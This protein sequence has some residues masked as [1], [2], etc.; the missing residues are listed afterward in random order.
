[1]VRIEHS[2]ISFVVQGPIVESTKHILEQVRKVFQDAEIILSTWKGSDTVGLDF[3]ILVENDD[4]GTVRGWS[5]DFPG[6]YYNV[7][8]Q[9]VS[10]YN[11]IKRAKSKY[12]VKMRSDL[13]ILNDS[14]LDYYGLLPVK[15]GYSFTKEKILITDVYTGSPTKN[16]KVPHCF[17]PG[18]WFFFGL[19][20]DLE[21]FF[22]LSL[23]GR[24]I[25]QYFLE[26]TEKNPDFKDLLC[27]YHPEQYLMLCNLQKVD[28]SVELE[29]PH[30][31]TAR[32]YTIHCKSLLSNF[33]LCNLE[34]F[35]KSSKYDTVEINRH[36]KG[37]YRRK[38]FEELYYAYSNK[39]NFD[40]LAYGLI[41]S[42]LLYKKFRRYFKQKRRKVKRLILD[43]FKEKEVAV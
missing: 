18:D 3:D 24:E 34:T 35:A 15:F 5:I 38:D 33:E 10:S 11:G 43:F 40:M 28:P 1:M 14:F 39:S 20:E 4:P 37:C 32:L 8:R 31:I 42:V 22:D 36:L 2:E 25:A 30:Y 17:H 27:R 13:V 16:K 21:S 12:V 19:K 7:D 9:I 41:K 23:A 6:S 26:R 29:Y